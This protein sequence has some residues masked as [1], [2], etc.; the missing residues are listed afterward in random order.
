MK[1]GV[2]KRIFCNGIPLLDG[3]GGLD[4]IEETNRPGDARF[5]GDCLWDFT[6]DDI[7]RHMDFGN[8]VAAGVHLQEGPAIGVGLDSIQEIP[9][10]LPDLVGN[11][12]DGRAVGNIPLDDLQ[13]GPGVVLKPCLADLAGPQGNGLL[14]G[15][16]HERLWNELLLDDEHAGRQVL[17]QGGPVRPGGDGGAEGAGDALDGVNGI[18]DGSTIRGRGLDD[19]DA[20][21]FLI[22]GGDGVL[23]VPVGDA[24]IDAVGRGVQSIAL[25]GLLLHKG[26]KPFGDIVDLDVPP[27]GGHIA[28]GDLA[29]QIDVIDSTVQAMV[30]TGD[31]L[32]EGDIGIPGRESRFLARLSRRHDFA[33]RMIGKKRLPPR[34]AGGGQHRPLGDL[35]LHD[36]GVDALGGVFLHLGLQFRVLVGF[37]AQQPV[38]ILN[39]LVV[40]IC[41]G[42]ASGVDVAARITARRFIALIV[43]D[44]RLERHEQG[45]GDLAGVVGDVAHHPFDVLFGDGV[46]LAQAGLG[47]SVIPQ[48]VR[49]R[50]GGGAVHV[51][52]E[53][54]LRARTV[55]V[56]Q[57][58]AVELPPRRRGRAVG[59]GLPLGVEP[60]GPEVGVRHRRNPHASGFC[61]HRHRWQEREHCQQSQKQCDDSLFHKTLSDRERWGS[62]LE[63]PLRLP[64]FTASYLDFECRWAQKKQ[65]VHVGRPALAYASSTDWSLYFELWYARIMSIFAMREE[66]KELPCF[67]STP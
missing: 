63:R 48:G 15:S 2:F 5:Q 67:R 45:A 22:L 40:G 41:V 46:H 36:G 39:V 8:F 30:R 26:P 49:I 12:L 44:V 32:L 62:P 14:T 33:V 13:S 31:D 54:R 11:S 64:P 59:I 28:A 55:R 56:A 29:V 9:V 52:L 18:F 3:Q 34:H 58:H 1:L 7:G 37:L 57:V 66:R 17:H 16:P 47:N 38:V 19:L 42:K 35:I 27:A 51:G 21:Q 50:S 25:R 6:D 60:G 53:K 24:D 65:A 10:D 4:R 23:A 61:R 43:P 20:G